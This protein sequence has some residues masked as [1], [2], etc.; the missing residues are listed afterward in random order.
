MNANSHPEAPTTARRNP[1]RK[2]VHIASTALLASLAAAFIGTFIAKSAFTLQA[3][4]AHSLGLSSGAFP[5]RTYLAETAVALLIPLLA[6]F[7][8]YGTGYGS[9]MPA[10]PVFPRFVTATGLTLLI[11]GVTGIADMYVSAY[12]EDPES[13]QAANA[14][15]QLDAL[16]AAVASTR[17]GITEE[18]LQLA[19]PTGTIILLAGA[20][21]AYRARRSKTPFPTRSIWIIA[22]IVGVLSSSFLRG[23]GHL[24]Q[25]ETSAVSGLIWGAAL[26]GVFLWVRSIWPLVLSHV[27]YDLSVASYS[28]LTGLTVQLVVA[29]ALL[30][31][32]G[33]LLLRRRAEQQRRDTE[34]HAE[35]AQAP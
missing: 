11:M 15:A 33:V 32:L 31:T 35:A 8:D 10:R 9:Q 26:A 34:R 28:S 5:Y 4:T 29:P 23:V 21:N 3:G 1:V 19:L 18:I 14:F 25:G 13:S 2:A 30:A 16:E 24:Y 7:S 22:G 27:L 17:A 6:R 12:V 20:V